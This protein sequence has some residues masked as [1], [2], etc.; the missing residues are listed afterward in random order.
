MFCPLQQWQM[1]VII[2]RR[3]SF[4]YPEN[5]KCNTSAWRS[6]ELAGCL[7]NF[8]YDIGA[9]SIDVQESKKDVGSHQIIQLTK[10]GAPS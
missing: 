6:G 9:L 5:A 4:A 8:T 10:R 7:H 2:V 3:M 1:D